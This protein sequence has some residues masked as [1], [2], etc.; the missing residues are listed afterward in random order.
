MSW[1]DFYTLTKPR[2]VQLL[3]FTAVIGMLLS[4][5]GM[6]PWTVLVFGG[7]G[8]GLAAGSA[9]AVN[10][11]L[12]RRFDE[13]M[14]RTRGR[15]LP[16]GRISERDAMAFAL[17]LG[18]IGIGILTLLINPLT[19]LLT[20]CALIGYAVIYTVY[21]KRTTPQNIVIGGAAGAAPPVLGWAAMQNEVSGYSL[22][23]FLIIFIWTPPHF[24]ALAIAR[25]SDYEKAEIPMLPVTHGVEVTKAYVLNYTFLLVI[26]TLLPFVTGMSGFLYLIAALLLG[27]GFIYYAVALRKSDDARIAMQ[28][29]HYSISY[30]V[31]L[32]SFLLLDHYIPH[33]WPG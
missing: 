25:K 8:I 23:L 28:T 19:A 18:L 15:P 3:V 5:P 4:T 22:L 33:V 9:A 27:A 11:V 30:L 13:A 17:A 10:H 7:L 20:F 1:R 32:F 16:M 14:A 31:A 2:V 6:V 12:D 26:V 21:L 24:W 29:F